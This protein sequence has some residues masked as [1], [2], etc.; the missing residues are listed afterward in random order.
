M[1]AQKLKY[2]DS[3]L[4]DFLRLFNSKGYFLELPA[5]VKNVIFKKANI[6]Y[7]DLAKKEQKKLEDVREYVNLMVIDSIEACKAFKANGCFKNLVDLLEY[8]VKKIKNSECL[9]DENLDN[10]HRIPLFDVFY[11][12]SFFNSSEML[13]GPRSFFQEFHLIFE[14]FSIKYTFHKVFIEILRV[15]LEL[16]LKLFINKNTSIIHEESVYVLDRV[17]SIHKSIHFNKLL[18][19]EL[20]VVI[21]LCNVSSDVDVVKQE[22]I[23]KELKEYV[24]LF[25][26][27]KIKRNVD[28]IDGFICCVCGLLLLVRVPELKSSMRKDKKL[29]ADFIFVFKEASLIEANII[30]H[31][32]VEMFSDDGFVKEE[33]FV[34]LSFDE[35]IKYF[36]YYHYFF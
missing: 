28:N 9:D 5:D 34:F 4:L 19:M 31:F 7:Q 17:R 3:V 23:L 26:E 11:Q 22:D 30:L 33:M 10:F 20:A 27:G 12:Y 18:S 36:C 29:L 2:G 1:N 24:N 15:L 16:L 8:C 13:W 21:T 32:L 35:L 14:V 6:Y 25:S